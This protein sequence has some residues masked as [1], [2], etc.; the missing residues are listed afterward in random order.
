MTVEAPLPADGSVWERL[1]VLYDRV[2]SV[3]ASSVGTPVLVG[4]GDCT[5]SLA[6]VAGLQRAGVSPSI[7]WFDAHGDVQTLE[8]TTSGYLGG[9]PLRMLTG[10][11]PELIARRL[12]LAPVPEDHVVLVDARDLDPPEREYLES[13][14]VRQVPVSALDASTLPDGPIY[15]HVDLDVVN[16]AELPGLLFPAPGGP[17]LADVTAAMGRVLDTGRVL[18]VGLGCTWHDDSA[19]ATTVRPSLPPGWE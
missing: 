1:A 8:T 13:S 7:V 9:M 15:L 11:R 6:T 17:S 2:A 4:S 19:A 10:Y 14:A 18:A 5:T 16:P 12:G 3:V